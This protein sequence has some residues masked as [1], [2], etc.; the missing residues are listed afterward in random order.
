MS[1][2]VVI[3]PDDAEQ[4]SSLISTMGS[5]QI[6]IVC[7]NKTAAEHFLHMQRENYEFCHDSSIA[8]CVGPNGEVDLHCVYLR[9]VADKKSGDMKCY[10]QRRAAGE[11]E[12]GDAEGEG[13]SAEITDMESGDKAEDSEP[14]AGKNSSIVTM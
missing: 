6:Y 8:D 13:S 3:R 12:G 1:T 4:L 9:C 11:V 10:R 2:S 5:D 14:P 7:P